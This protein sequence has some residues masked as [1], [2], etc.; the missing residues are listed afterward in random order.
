MRSS[1]SILGAFERLEGSPLAADICAEG[2][3]GIDDALHGTGRFR[4]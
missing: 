2:L 3:A 1:S 4:Y